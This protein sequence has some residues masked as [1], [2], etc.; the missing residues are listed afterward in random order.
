MQ[1]GYSFKDEVALFEVAHRHNDD[2][3]AIR[4]AD[5]RPDALSYLSPNPWS[6]GIRSQS[7]VITTCR[8]FVKAGAGANGFGKPSGGVILDKYFEL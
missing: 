7:S 3:P 2:L 8:L 4:S 1:V 5:F 6:H